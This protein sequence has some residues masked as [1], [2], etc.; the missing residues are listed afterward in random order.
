MPPCSVPSVLL[1]QGSAVI[2]NPVSRTVNGRLKIFFDGGYRPN[3]GLSEA[4]AVARGIV[5]YREGFGIGSSTEAEWLALIH[6]LEVAERL[7]E[8][9]VELIG[10]SITVVN[11][12]R[13]V[14]KCRGETLPAYRARFL[15][16]ATS[17]TTLRV[18]HVKRSHNLAGIALAARHR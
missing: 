4:A 1:A 11:Q 6:A 10:D 16:L 2:P 18:R 15:A 13:G 9:D 17:F 7:G 3:R 12:A 5:Y 14:A 8:R